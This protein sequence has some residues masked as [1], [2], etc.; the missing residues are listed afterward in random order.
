MSYRR[1]SN[2]ANFEFEWKDAQ[3]HVAHLQHRVLKLTAQP[4]QAP[5]VAPTVEKGDL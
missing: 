4:P 3:G 5:Y 1:E 2:L